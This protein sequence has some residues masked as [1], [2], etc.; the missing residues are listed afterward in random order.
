MPECKEKGRRHRERGGMAGASHSF[1]P[2]KFIEQLL[3]AP[4]H[5]GQCKPRTK[6][7]PSE[8]CAAQ[9]ISLSEP[10]PH[11]SLTTK[12]TI[13]LLLSLSQKSLHFNTDATWHIQKA[14]E[15]S[16]SLRIMSCLC[17]PLTLFP[18]PCFCGDSQDVPWGGGLY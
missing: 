12:S 1:L 10:A 16:G 13:R 18:L 11:R 6:P 14:W 17:I 4:Y 2:T 5:C 9:F 3:W 7:C 15:E 8:A